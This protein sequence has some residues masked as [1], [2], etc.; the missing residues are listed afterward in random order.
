MNGLQHIGDAFSRAKSQQRAALMPYFTLG[1]PTR[2]ASLE[3]VEAIASSG[4]DLIEL[5]LPF[6]DPLADGPTIQHSTQVALE[7]GITVE[8]CLGLV[9]RLRGRGVSQPL[10]LMGY[11]NPLLAYGPERFVA[12]ARQAGA[13]G[14]IVPDLPLE[15]AGDLELACL[16]NGLAL[17]YLVAPTTTEQR[18]AQVTAHST[19]F[20]YI[21]SLTGVTG[22]RSS[23]SA[24]LQDFL[25]RV[26]NVTDKPLAVGFGI[27]TPEQ[28]ARVGMLAEGVIVG[29]ALIDIAGKASEPALAAGKFV[30][31]INKALSILSK[32]N[33]QP[34]KAGFPGS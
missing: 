5:G 9:Q 2:S 33:S 6:S 27:S 8:D 23:L 22:A 1:Y 31:E 26:R 10:L 14:L 20:V 15:E 24:D 21:V 18:L 19:G 16:Q 30:S 17:V 32:T 29:S 12:A 13:D 4:A 3:V 11:Y 34:S 28:A 25:Q 7:N